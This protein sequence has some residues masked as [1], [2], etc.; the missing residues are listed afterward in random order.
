MMKVSEVAKIIKWTNRK[1][2]Y[3]MKK[4]SIAEKYG[5][6]YYVQLRLLR[7]HF[8]DIYNLVKGKSPQEKKI[9]IKVSEVAKIIGWNKDKT[10]EWMIREKIAIKQGEHYYTSKELLKKNFKEVYNMIKS[11]KD[12]GTN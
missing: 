2:L 11:G 1:T 9:Y 3:W 7:K 4:K 5:K 6:H 10:R 8:I 12:Q